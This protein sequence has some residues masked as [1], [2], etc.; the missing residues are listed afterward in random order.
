MNRVKNKL[1][2]KMGTYSLRAV[3]MTR[4]NGCPWEDYEA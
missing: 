1:Q 4:L 3:M 2:N